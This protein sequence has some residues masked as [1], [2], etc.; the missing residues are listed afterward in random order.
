MTYYE[1]KQIREYYLINSYRE[2]IFFVCGKQKCTLVYWTFRQ[3]LS[4]LQ[5]WTPVY[6]YR[7]VYCQ[8]GT[9][10]NGITVLLGYYQKKC[11]LQNV[12]GMD[13]PNQCL[14][15]KVERMIYLFNKSS[16]ININC[17]P[18]KYHH[19]M[20]I[21]PRTVLDTSPEDNHEDEKSLRNQGLREHHKYRNQAYEISGYCILLQKFNVLGDH[22]VFEVKLFHD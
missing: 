17:M 8:H 16:A 2:I 1:A 18:E 21:L 6:I 14:M 4:F 7:Y 22:G 13:I 20:I 5:W 10:K 3:C 15:W 12:Y 11:D 9:C 19:V